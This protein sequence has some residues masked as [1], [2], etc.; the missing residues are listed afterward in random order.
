MPAYSVPANM[1]RT[2]T[3]TVTNVGPN[4]PTAAINV[5]DT[6]P[7]GLTGI[8][9]SRLRMELHSCYAHLHSF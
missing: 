6:L 9:N 4:T 7:I 3:V 1:G 5:I 2:Y 8:G